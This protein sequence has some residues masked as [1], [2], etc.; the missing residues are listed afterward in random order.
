MAEAPRPRWRLGDLLPGGA[1]GSV[2]GDS[3]GRRRVRIGLTGLARAGKTAFLT[4]V[5]ANLLALSRGRGEALPALSA[6][7]GGVPLIRPSDAGAESLP[8]FDLATHLAALAADPPHWPPR[9]DTTALLAL[10]VDLPARVSGLPPRRLRLEF[11]DYPG[12]WLLDLPLLG[13]EFGVWSAGVLA[14]LRDPALAGLA[15]PFLAFCDAMDA[16]AAADETLARAGHELYV[17]LLKAMRDRLGLSLLQPGR[18]LMP[19]PGALPPW[20]VFFPMVGRG[21]LARLLGERF[22]AYRGAIAADLTRPLF[23]SIDRLVVLADLLTP[24]HLGAASFAD[25]Q[26]AL[27]AATRALRWRQ[28]WSSLLGAEG[29][30]RLAAGLGPA[31]SEAFAGR[32]LSALASGAG[33]AGGIGRVAWAAT[34]ADHVARAQRGNLAALIGRLT[35]SGHSTGARITE[36]HFAIASIRCTEDFVWSL[37][38]RPVSAVRGRLL[39]EDTLTRSYP[40]E[41]PDMPPDAAFFT[42]PFLSI[43]HFEPIRPPGG[44]RDGVPQIGLDGL[45]AFLLEDLL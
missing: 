11:L 22:D 27:A 29:W 13:V 44:G 4:S 5:A 6:R 2:L 26:G 14:R 15:T 23:A 28:G 40:G 36:A 32:N 19:P 12:E 18:F 1:L 20:M 7:L 16:K 31:L 25:A 8:R 3:L 42:H 35:E 30:A 39:G 21:G 41:V 24:L 33:P 45:L 43:P 9:T 38:G 10:D 34:K 37:D 17:T